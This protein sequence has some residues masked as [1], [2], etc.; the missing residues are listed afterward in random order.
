MLRQALCGLA[1]L[2]AWPTGAGAASFSVDPVR[3]SLSSS[4]PLS[5]IAVRNNGAEATVVQVDTSRWS[6]SAGQMI[7]EPTRDVLATP[8]IFT[9]SAGGTQ[10]VRLGLRRP[11]DSQREL[12]YRVALHE[13]VKSDPSVSGLRV[14]LVITIPIFV[15]PPVT[16]APKLQWHVV[17]SGSGGWRLEVAN[18]GNAHVRLANVELTDSDTGKTFAKQDLAG[19][20]LADESRSWILRP[21]FQ[22]SN[23]PVLIRANTDAGDFES[24]TQLENDVASS[25]VRT[26]ADTTRF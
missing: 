14:A 26:S 12:T 6:Q 9:I 3:I 19:Y 21:I 20:V 23:A 4:T 17:R 8:P 13:V 2:L 11:V 7:L 22:P 1:L 16:S 15:Q 25:D 18:T 10:V 5:S 24:R